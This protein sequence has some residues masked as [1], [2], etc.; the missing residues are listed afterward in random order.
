MIYESCL[1]RSMALLFDLRC[2][3]CIGILEDCVYGFRI[4][5]T[6]LGYQF[7]GARI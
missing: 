5:H 6:L 3:R 1:S 2:G 7:S 4:W